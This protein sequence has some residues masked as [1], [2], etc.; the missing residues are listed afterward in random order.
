M[1]GGGGVKCS[2]SKWE[3]Q[4]SDP[5]SLQKSGGCESI[6]NPSTLETEAGAPGQAGPLDKLTNRTAPASMRGFAS[7]NKR[8]R[9]TE[10]DIDVSFRPTHPCASTYMQTHTHRNRLTQK[11][12]QKADSEKVC[13][14][15]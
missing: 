13:K 1:A 14:I 4:G 6:C 2:P 3:S 10:E 12:S 11:Q 8:H 5:R 9:V 7:I 15:L